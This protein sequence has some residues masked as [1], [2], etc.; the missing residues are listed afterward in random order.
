MKNYLRM[1]K[2]LEAV[3]GEE[4]KEENLYRWRRRIAARNSITIFGS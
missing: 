4:L 2:E 3:A 1:I